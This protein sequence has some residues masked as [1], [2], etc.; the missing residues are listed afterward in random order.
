MVPMRVVEVL[1]VAAFTTGCMKQPQSREEL[2]LM[3]RQGSWSTKL[4]TKVVEADFDTVAALL[5]AKSSECLDKFVDRSG[6]TGGQMHT[7]SSQY[8][9]TWA[10][11]SPDRAELTLQVVHSPRGVGG[12]PMPE[13][14]YYLL[15]ADLERR[16]PSSS[17]YTIYYPTISHGDVVDAV[18]S[19]LEGRAADCPSF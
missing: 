7:G 19:W 9:P 2:V 4:E 13:R 18:R 1:L 3:I 8:N 15:A 14:G 16:P 17:E 11:V 5:E 12:G 6:M 10:R